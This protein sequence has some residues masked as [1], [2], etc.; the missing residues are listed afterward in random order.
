MRLIIS[1]ILIGCTL[2][3]CEENESTS[4]D[5][6]GNESVYALNPGS[7]Y[8]TSGTVTFKEKM[9]GT[10]LIVVDLEG[11]EGNVKHP[12]HLHLGSISTPG[13]DVTALLTPVIGK[14]GKSET[15]LTKL[16]DESDVTYNDL[17]NLSA[18]VKVHLAEAGPDKDIIL[19]GGNIGKAAL[20]PSS[21]RSAMKVC[22]SE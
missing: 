18:C 1:A 19:A 3:S 8:Q 2:A 17:L 10:A 12:V 11:T 5:F 16:A 9:D 13:A 21:G 4:N 6:T 14:T 22:K 15:N 20:D 7:T